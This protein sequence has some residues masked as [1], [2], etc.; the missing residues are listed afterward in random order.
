VPMP[1]T[2]TQRV[3]VSIFSPI[4]YIAHSSLIASIFYLIMS[5][6]NSRTE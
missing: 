2:K 1:R 3:A 5:I 6:Y 4:A